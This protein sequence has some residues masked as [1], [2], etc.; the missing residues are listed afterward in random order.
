MCAESAKTIT[1][2]P[3]LHNINHEDINRFFLLGYDCLGYSMECHW[4]WHFWVS[5]LHDR[6]PRERQ[7]YE[8]TDRMWR[9]RRVTINWLRFVTSHCRIFDSDFPVFNA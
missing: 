3:R 4:M 9:S 5:E 8:R 1:Q 2:T 6:L 7:S